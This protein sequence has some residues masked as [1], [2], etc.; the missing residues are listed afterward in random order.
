MSRTKS[1]NVVIML[2]QRRIDLVDDE[3]RIYLNEPRVAQTVRA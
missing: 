1:D 3:N 2:L